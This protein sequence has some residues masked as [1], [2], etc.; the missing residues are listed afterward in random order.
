M[1]LLRI[2]VA[3]HLLGVKVR[4][5]LE[6]EC[7][8]VQPM[9]QPWRG[10]VD[11]AGKLQQAGHAAG[12]VVRT[13]VGVAGD[14][15][16]RADD[17]PWGRL[18]TERARNVLVLGAID[19]EFLRFQPAARL[20]EGGLDKGGRLVQAVDTPAVPRRRQRR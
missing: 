8:Q 19:L 12:V 9:R 11:Q 15:V 17:H 16:V 10:C 4:R 7:D 18:R 3:A 5:F 14:I 2:D 20:G 13:R 6:G 1:Q